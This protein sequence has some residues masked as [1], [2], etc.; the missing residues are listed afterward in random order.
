MILRPPR[1]TRTYTLFPYTT[2]FRSDAVPIGQVTDQ[3][4]DHH[5]AGSG[6]YH[7]LDLIDVDVVGAFGRI[8]E[9]GDQLLARDRSD[10]RRKGEGGG[11][12]LAARRQ[13]Q[14]LNGQIIGRRPRIDPDAL[15][16][17]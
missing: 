15:F 2:L 3:R 4:R 5:R 6:R 9:G 1:S 12:H 16:L 14:K 17:V 13:V 10:G 7:R 8:D 11:Y